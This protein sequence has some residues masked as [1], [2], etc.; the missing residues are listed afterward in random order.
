MPPGLSKRGRGGTAGSSTDPA[1][2][3]YGFWNP[4]PL[5][6]RIDCAGGPAGQPA[7]RV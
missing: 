2:R 3:V 5:E 6:G 7:V 4:F 1:T